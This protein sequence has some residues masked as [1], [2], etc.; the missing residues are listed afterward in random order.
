[1]AQVL[2]D[3][4]AAVQLDP[5]WLKG[6]YYRCTTQQPAAAAAGLE[7]AATAAAAAAVLVCCVPTAVAT[8]NYLRSK[9]QA[10]TASSVSAVELCCQWRTFIA[11]GA[12]MHVCPFSCPFA[13]Y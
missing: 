1:V 8:D 12:D 3:A 9:G 7:A 13:Y 6:H 5:S 2:A 11:A 10:Q 4:E